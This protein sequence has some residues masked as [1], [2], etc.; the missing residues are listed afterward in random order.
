MAINYRLD[1]QNILREYCGKV[2][3]DHKKFR[4]LTQL[5]F[6]FTW[7]VGE[8]EFDKKDGGMIIALVRKVPGWA[9]DIL[10]KDIELRVNFEQWWAM[11]DS[12]R[13]R[14]IFHE[15]SHIKLEIDEEF[16]VVLDDDERP[17]FHITGHDLIIKTFVEEVELFGVPPEYTRQVVE[18]GKLVKPPEIPL[19]YETAADEL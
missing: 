13:Y 6:I 10:K 12:R 15:L 2:M 16:K 19:M 4:I 7:R 1:D 14:L 18:L 3:Q 11:S 8:P 9:R 17:K 5:R